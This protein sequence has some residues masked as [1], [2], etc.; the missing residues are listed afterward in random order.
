MHKPEGE[1]IIARAKDLLFKYEV[2][3]RHEAGLVLMGTE[4]KSL[5]EGRANLKDSYCRFQGLELFLVGTHISMYSHGTHGNHDP[6]RPRKLLLHKRELTRLQS[7][8]AEKGLSI[9]PAKLYFKKG[10]AKLEI[11]LVKGK[12]LYDR[13]EDIKRKTVNREMERAIKRYK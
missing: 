3:E 9:V 4:V 2:M 6:E 10:K 7:K 8:V 5:R 1:K 13:R 11:A 12:K